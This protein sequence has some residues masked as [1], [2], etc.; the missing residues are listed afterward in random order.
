MALGPYFSVQAK[1]KLKIFLESMRNSESYFVICTI[2]RGKKIYSLDFQLMLEIRY[3]RVQT[4]LK[5]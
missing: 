1:N 2:T 3:I 4:S 5:V